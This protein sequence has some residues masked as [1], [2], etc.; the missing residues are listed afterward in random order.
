MSDGWIFALAATIIGILIGWVAGR[1]RERTSA[2]ERTTE[3]SRAQLSAVLIPRSQGGP[4]LV[5]RNAGPAAARDLTVMVDGRPLG[6][7]GCFHRPPP[8]EGM[9][10]A[11]GERGFRLINGDNLPD[12]FHVEV[13][14]ADDSG[15]GRRWASNLSLGP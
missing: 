6:Q 7:H 2:A 10:G 3:R 13:R 5:V 14:W 8:D 9:L 4:A 12:L 15:P 1:R 11:P